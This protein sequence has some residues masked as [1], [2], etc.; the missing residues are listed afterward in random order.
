MHAVFSKM[1]QQCA[2]FCV[3]VDILQQHCYEIGNV[4]LV[5]RAGRAGDDF[6][7]FI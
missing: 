5:A 1:P 6:A 4:F 7:V 3:C 2:F